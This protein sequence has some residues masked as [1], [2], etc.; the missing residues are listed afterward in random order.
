MWPIRT[1]GKRLR[2]VP[3]LVAIVGVTACAAPL[4]RPPA[5]VDQTTPR[6]DVQAHLPAVHRYLARRTAQPPRIDGRLDDP[7]WAAAPWTEAFTDIE[8]ATRPR[9]RFRTRVKM[10]WDADHW[11]IAAE[12]SEPDLWATIRQRD[13]VI[14]RDNDFEIFVDPSG[15]TH[16]YF[17][18][19]MNQ[20]ATVWDLF[21]PKPYR[22][23]GSPDNGWNIDGLQIAVQLHGTVNHPGDRDT[24][25][26]VELA[27]PWRALADSGRNRVPP[28]AGEQ[29]RVNFSRV[30]WDVDTTGGR[31]AKRTDAA[32]KPLPEHNWVWSPQGAIDM[33]MPEMW[34]VVQFGGGHMTRDV[35][36]DVARWQ[37]RR[38]YYGEHRYHAGHGSYATSLAALRIEHLPSG[39]AFTATP[40]AW[41]ATVRASDGRAWQIRDD[42]LV[43]ARSA[44]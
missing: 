24:S 39:I 26:T 40:T 20:F 22:D 6:A 3:T 16:R 23:Q 5:A 8:G 44:P 12:I 41:Q 36:A 43:T 28:R 19:E 35:T 15:T 42:G 18:I 33:H 32:G 21:L 25:W 38:V 30:E 11:Y 31:Y 10:L 37:L 14:F 4:R 1:F 2:P 17:E 13:A 34:G 27:I 29:W 7:A 9:P